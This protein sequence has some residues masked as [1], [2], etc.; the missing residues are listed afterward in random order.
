LEEIKDPKALELETTKDEFTTLLEYSMLYIN[1]E[2]IE[3]EKRRK[4]S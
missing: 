2:E 1:E 4:I 3:A